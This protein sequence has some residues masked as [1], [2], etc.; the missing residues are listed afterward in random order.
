MKRPFDFRSH[1]PIPVQW[2]LPC[3]KYL[4]LQRFA[5]RAGRSRI[6]QSP[7]VLY[8]YYGS[9]KRGALLLRAKLRKA[10]RAFRKRSEC[11]DRNATDFKFATTCVTEHENQFSQENPFPGEGNFIGGLDDTGFKA[12]AALYVAQA[13]RKTPATKSSTGTEAGRLTV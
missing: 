13:N 1:D 11:L 3:G 5:Q 9:A 4:C 10:S 2:R 12:A 8:R 6:P 7:T